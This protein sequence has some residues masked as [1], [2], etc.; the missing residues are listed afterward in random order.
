MNNIVLTGM[1][2]KRNRFLLITG[3]VISFVGI[4][5]DIFL[6]RSFIS[7]EGWHYDYFHLRE[8]R[9]SRIASFFDMGI[10]EYHIISILYFLCLGVFLYAI[11]SNRK[12]GKPL[13]QL[14][15]SFNIAFCAFA[16]QF[17][18]SILYILYDNYDDKI[19]AVSFLVI[20][21][22]TGLFFSFYI[23]RSG[24]QSKL[25]CKQLNCL[26]I[27][28]MI[29]LWSSLAIGVFNIYTVYKEIDI[30][31]NGWSAINKVGILKDAME[32]IPAII[33][34]LLFNNMKKNLEA[35]DVNVKE[36]E[37]KPHVE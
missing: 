28:S 6:I 21:V 29:C 11:H 2:K 13:M 31:S 3:I 18:L 16:F 22:N 8:L 34:L 9:I 1:H 20:V 7:S 4:L 33:L 15:R 5:S 10:M 32:V 35:L 36:L 27:F 12:N 14:S 37:D 23:I 26:L 17:C 24:F 19:K 30:S 25:G